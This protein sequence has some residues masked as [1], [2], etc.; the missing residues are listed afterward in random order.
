MSRA[1]PRLWDFSLHDVK[2]VSGMAMKRYRFILLFVFLAMLAAPLAAQQGKGSLWLRAD[3]FL[4]SFQENK[5]NDTTFYY[6][7]QQR[8]RVGLVMQERMN[9]S[10]LAGTQDNER[11]SALFRE[12][13]YPSIGI[14]A[15]YRTL[16]CTFALG[17][18]WKNKEKR[19]I[20]L[21]YR[22]AGNQWG[23]EAYVTRNNFS[24]GTLTSGGE[25]TS[26]PDGSLV[27]QTLDIDSYYS[28][29]YKHFSYPAAV[30]HAVLQ[31]R[32]SGGVFIC[33][34]IHISGHEYA[35]DPSLNICSYNF[36]L[37]A[38]YGY[39][40]VLP[41]QWVVHI[42]AVPSF[43]VLGASSEEFGEKPVFH[44]PLKRLD[45]IGTETVA[46]FHHWKNYYAGLTS[47][48]RA[49]FIGDRDDLSVCTFR[50]KASLSAGIYF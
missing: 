4:R 33:S 3:D 11:F 36:S 32:S 17:P 9:G 49:A 13:P 23:I 14:Y 15:A 24:N 48:N 5:K 28:L 39:S 43:V 35:P 16:G 29:N 21:G 8:F 6:R 30:N 10:Y 47:T 44:N 27:M 12:D 19:N 22:F 20:N 7:P 25:K 37:G 40:L 38:G 42:S 31:K 45:F 18:F 50:H 34:S 26:L 46:I 2:A 1:V 41:G